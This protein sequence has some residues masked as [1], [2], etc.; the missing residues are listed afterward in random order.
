MYAVNCALVDTFSRA[1]VYLFEGKFL[2][3]WYFSLAV[4]YNFCCALIEMIT[5]FFVFF[6]EFSNL[7]KL[8][9]VELTQYLFQN[10]L[11]QNCFQLKIFAF[12]SSFTTLL[13]FCFV[14]SSSSLVC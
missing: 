4:V 1:A 7:E 13:F 12:F 11:F 9:F 6:L 2:L 10:S 5:I 14:F 3:L 8:I